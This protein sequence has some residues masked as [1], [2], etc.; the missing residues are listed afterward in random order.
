MASQMEFL[1]PT[2]TFI[3]FLPAT[4]YLKWHW[5]TNVEKP[6]VENGRQEHEKENRVQDEEFSRGMRSQVVF[7]GERKEKTQGH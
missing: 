3:Y 1:G 4:L 2:V 6:L 7:R 5:D